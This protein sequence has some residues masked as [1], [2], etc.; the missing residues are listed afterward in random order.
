MKQYVRRKG[1]T[2]T[3]KQKAH[4]ARMRG[5]GNPAKRADVSSKISAAKKKSNPGSFVKGVKHTE[6]H[7]QK[8]AASRIGI[9]PW[10]K[11]KTGVVKESQK[12]AIRAANRR[13]LTK[14]KYKDTSI[15]IKVEE[16]LKMLGVEYVK[17]HHVPGVVVVDF[18]VPASNLVIEADGCRWH[19]CPVHSPHAFPN[20]PAKDALRTRLMQDRGYSVLRIWEHDI[21]SMTIRKLS[22]FISNK[23]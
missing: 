3:D 11:G 22:N 21:N 19:N 9:E 17:Q 16:A 6:E 5:S 8:I 1:A 13:N 15:E 12:R 14:H 4:Y 18:Y 2:L 23:L 7:K 20:K 10:N